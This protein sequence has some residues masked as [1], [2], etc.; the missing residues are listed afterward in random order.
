[1]AKHICPRPR[2]DSGRISALT[3]LLSVPLTLLMTL[4]AL[5]ACGSGNNQ[6]ITQDDLGSVRMFNGIADSPALSFT[7]ENSTFATLPFGQVSG[8]S[9]TVDGRFDVDVSFIA[10]DTTFTT[11]VDDFRTEVREQEQTTVVV[12]GSI[13]APV[14]FEFN[15]P[16][17]NIP[18]GTTEF[19]VINTGNAGSVDFHL[20][21][22][23]ADLGAPTTSVANNAVS[24]LL[25]TD[26]GSRRIRL[27]APGSSDVIYDSGSF[28]LANGSRL[29]FHVKPYFGP[30]DNT[31]RV[32]NIDGTRS[33]GF[34]NEELPVSLRIANAIADV[35]GAD[36]AVVV[37][38]TTTETTDIPSNSFSAPQLFSA[39]SA[40]L[41]VNMQTD[42][43]TPFFIDTQLLVAGEQRTLLVAGS[44][45][46]GTTVGRLT[47]EPVRP[48]STSAQIN[49]LQG[50]ISSGRIDVYLLEAGETTETTGATIADL[51]LL[52]NATREVQAG[53]YD[54]VVTQNGVTTVLADPVPLTLENGDI[55][56]ILVTDADSGGLPPRIILGEQP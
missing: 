41:Q 21:P 16:N 56:T 55:R 27:T 19:H 40:D 29:I 18:T 12:T 31:V 7:L 49:V 32:A 9:Q 11:L 53:T 52:A 15:A 43:G 28:E 54:V 26:S 2:T 8:F 5:T 44:V 22:D 45:T 10:I 38:G 50:T 34:S 24:E 17:P 46:N 30:G 4:F 3:G 39:G 20:T 37:N 14:I 13:A 6:S 48:I 35:A 33:T 25:S 36:T 42:P 1:M 51:T 23:N 47:I